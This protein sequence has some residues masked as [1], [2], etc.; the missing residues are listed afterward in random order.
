[1]PPGLS[2]REVPSKYN[3]AYWDVANRTANDLGERRAIVC[4]LRRQAGDP[5]ISSYVPLKS[6]ILPL[7]NCHTRVP[8]S[9]NKS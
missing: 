1:M 6:T 8:T 4:S 9:S 5:I 7:S 2:S 3:R